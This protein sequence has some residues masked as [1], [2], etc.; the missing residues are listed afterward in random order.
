MA[1]IWKLPLIA[2]CEN[3]LYAVETVHRSVT[4]RRRPSPSGRPASGC[5]RVQVDGQDVG[6]VYRRLR[7]A[8]ERA[9]AGEGPTFIEALTYRY[10]GHNTGEVADLPHERTRSSSGGPSSDP[11]ERLRRRSSTPALLD[12]AAL[13]RRSTR[14]RRDSVAAAVAFAEASPYAGPGHR[15]STTCPAST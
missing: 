3:N 6:A 14:R 7:E 13:R 11:I 8:R 10:H 15:R 4:G 9:L 2:V 1:A 5:R 12:A